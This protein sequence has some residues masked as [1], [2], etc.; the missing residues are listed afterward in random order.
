MAKRIPLVLSVL[1]L[2][3]LGAALLSGPAGFGP[4]EQSAEAA[5]LNEARKLLASDAQD[6]D[7]FGMSVAISG[8]TAVVGAPQGDAEGGD[9]GAAYVFQRD[10]GG[11]NNWSEVKKLTASDGGDRDYFGVSVAISGD[12]AVVTAAGEA[13]GGLQPGAA[14]VF[15]RDAGG[16]D[17]W[18]EV[19]KLTASDG[20]AAEYHLFGDSVAVSGDTVVVG[21]RLAFGF[22]GAAYVFE[23]DAGG[24]DNWGEVKKLTASDNQASFDHFGYSVAVSGET[25]LVGAELENGGGAAYVYGR[26]EGGAG[27][28]GQVKRLTSSD[29]DGSGSIGDWFGWSVAVN[30]DTAI[31]A[32]VLDNQFRTAAAYVFGRD[33]GGADN[34]GEVKKLTASDAELYDGFGSSVALSGDTVVVGAYSEPDAGHEAGAAYVYRRDQGGAGNWGEVSKLTASDG[35]AGDWLGWSAAV[36]GDTA[37]FGAFWED[38]GASDAGAAYVFDLAFPKATPTP[39][40]DFDG[41]TICDD[42][43]ADDDNDGCTD[44]QE[45]TLVP[46]LGGLRDPHSYWDF[47]DTP[48]AANSRDRHIDIID[49]GAL[50]T[51]FAAVGEPDGDPLSPPPP[52]PAYHT[53]FDRGGPI[54]GQE[55]WNLLQADGSINI[56]DLGAMIVQFGHTCA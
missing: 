29:N 25:V 50:V 34:W 28:W 6:E 4:G 44:V 55:L 33:Q 14:Y 26:D 52:A 30:G 13:A 38:S 15:E 20:Q 10:A 49:I 23:R 46:S 35:Q 7:F 45:A 37:V 1:A 47:F 43:D 12:T 16:A 8:D 36:S 9:V 11:P 53:S 48:G 18:G 51:R 2:A 41:D 42:A 54:P 22:A 56:L 27:N 24:A 39:C 32:A 21:A 40:P 3:A 17:N 19:S 31:V 5:L